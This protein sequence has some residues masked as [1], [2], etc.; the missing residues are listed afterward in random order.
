M[1]R[2]VYMKCMRHNLRRLPK[3]DYARAI[4]Y[5]KEYF[6]E[7]GPDSEQQA[8]EDLGSPDMAANQIIRDLAVENAAQPDA[9][10]KKGISAVWIGIL[11]IF[12]APIGFPLAFAAVVLALSVVLVF[13]CLMLSLLI[14]ALSVGIS[15]IPLLGGSIWLLFT[16]PVDG[17]VNMGIS[18]IVIGIGIWVVKVCIWLCQ[19][20]FKWFLHLMT[21]I[22]GTIA[23]KGKNHEK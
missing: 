4:D 9:S 16:S 3:E 17:I 5:F 23:R 1:N 7:A 21:R 12:A 6:E 14:A 13:I 22:F 8:I 18:L 11:V 19:W 10:V 2:E 20:L 15:A